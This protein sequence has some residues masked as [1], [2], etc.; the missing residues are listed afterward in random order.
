MGVQEDQL[1]ELQVISGLLRKL[2]D[3]APLRQEI[4]PVCLL[5]LVSQEPPFRLK[6]GKVVHRKCE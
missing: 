6:E 1:E 5:P 4:C 3:D 2:N